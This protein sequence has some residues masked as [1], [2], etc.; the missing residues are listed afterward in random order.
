MC[1]GPGHRTVY[2]YEDNAEVGTVRRKA[3]RDRNR[4]TSTTPTGKQ[5]ARQH[6]FD[7]FDR[8]HQF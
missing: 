8:T 6:G 7:G 2:H 1:S 3:K 4:T 5:G